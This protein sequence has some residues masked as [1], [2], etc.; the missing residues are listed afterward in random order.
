MRYGSRGNAR[1]DRRDPPKL[2]IIAGCYNFGRAIVRELENSCARSSHWHG[3]M[4]NV[5]LCVASPTVAWTAQSDVPQS[6]AAAP[7]SLNAI[8]WF[9]P[10]Q[11][12]DWLSVS[13]YTSAQWYNAINVEALDLGRAWRLGTILELQGRLGAFH[14]QGTRLDTPDPSDSN[15]TSSGATVGIG[16]R[17]Y[18][19]EVRRMRIFIEGAVEIL[20]TP[21]G[22]E[23]PP[24]GTGV[25]AFLRG[26]GGVQCQITKELALEAHFEYAHVS[27]GGGS[28]PQ[29]PMWNGRGG[30]ISIRR[31][32]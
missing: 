12:A 24:G 22:R 26:G 14:A 27:N 32:L 28:V 15:S 18:P 29:N 13:Y 20:Y 31:S 8:R 10:I 7:A 4:L 21:G 2:S 17:V 16:S 19:L 1:S 23:F 5:F 9:P 30:G 11:T 6:P 3:L 25:N